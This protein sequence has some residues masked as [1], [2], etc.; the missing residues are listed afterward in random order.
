M[1]RCVATGPYTYLKRV[2]KRRLRCVD[3]LI[4][5]L[6][7]KG[8]DFMD[9]QF[10][11]RVRVSA[12]AGRNKKRGG[13]RQILSAISL[14]RTYRHAQRKGRGG[15]LQPKEKTVAEDFFEERRPWIV[16]PVALDGKTWGRAKKDRACF[17]N[18]STLLKRGCRAWKKT[19]FAFNGRGQKKEEGNSWK[20]PVHSK[21][22]K[23]GGALSIL[24]GKKSTRTCLSLDCRLHE[25][26]G[27]GEGFCTDRNP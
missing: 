15:A 19:Y 20:L 8:N 14:S 21:K 11:N 3:I 13:G 1:T 12:Y 2:K 10:A 7:K 5:S 16:F 6:S 26:G 27:G 17:E 24:G 22:R 4:S 18:R 25:E 23:T 9:D